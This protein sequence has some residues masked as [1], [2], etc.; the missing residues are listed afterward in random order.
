MFLSTLT[1]QQTTYSSDD[2]PEERLWGLYNSVHAVLCIAAV[3]SKHGA[4][5][6]SC[7]YTTARLFIFR[8]TL[9][10]LKKR[11]TCFSYMLIS[12]SY[13]YF[14]CSCIFSRS[15]VESSARRE[16]VVCD[17]THRTSSKTLNSV[18]ARSPCLRAAAFRRSC[19]VTDHHPSTSRLTF[20]RELWRV[21]DERAR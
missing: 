2:C 1:L 13:G 17:V 11:F 18:L 12:F 16:R 20:L 19:T 15:L 5:S 4:H 8:L 3:P 6:H 9:S 14:V 7:S 21:H 10:F